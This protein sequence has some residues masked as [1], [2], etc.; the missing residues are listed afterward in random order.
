MARSSIRSG[1]IALKVSG[2]FKGHRPDLAVDRDVDG[3]QFRG[4]SVSAAI[5]GASVSQPLVLPF[6]CGR[7]H[8]QTAI[9]GTG[10][11]GADR[12]R[13]PLAAGCAG[14]YLFRDRD[15]E[16]IYVGKAVS[17]RKRVASH[18]SGGNAGMT[19]LIERIEFSPPN[20]NPRP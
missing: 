11:R 9:K 14:V 10:P 6:A 5:G 2:R 15:D 12:C 3:F 1:L 19:R 13:A 20:R 8:R 17:I 4:V 18:F 7:I 16:V